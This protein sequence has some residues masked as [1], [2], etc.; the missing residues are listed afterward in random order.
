MSVLDK[1]F[2]TDAMLNC[3]RDEGL[4]LQMPVAV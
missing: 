2:V 1:T 4:Y 3:I